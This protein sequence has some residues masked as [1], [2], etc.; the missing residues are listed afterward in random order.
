VRI[1]LDECVNPRVK[2]LL[3]PEHVVVTVL[4][5][6]W[7]GCRDPVLVKRL[8]G[9]CEVFLTI[10]RGFEHEHNLSLLDYGIVIVHVSRNRLAHYE[11]IR[12]KMIQALSSVKAGEAIHVG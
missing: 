3:E 4:E 1:V 10:D 6:G 9:H 7:G 5:L 8:Q 2:R 11:A 12:E